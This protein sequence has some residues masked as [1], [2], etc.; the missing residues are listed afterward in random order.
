MG[1]LRIEQIFLSRMEKERDQTWVALCYR[2][3]RYHLQFE[4]IRFWPWENQ[5]KK[6]DRLKIKL[7]P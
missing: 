6:M 1:Q 5:K 7:V 3:A 4:P 2:D